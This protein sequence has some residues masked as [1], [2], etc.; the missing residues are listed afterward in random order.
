[1]SSELNLLPAGAKFQAERVRFKKTIRI[2]LMVFSGVW[3]FLTLVVFLWQLVVQYSVEGSEKKYQKAF[4]VYKSLAKEAGDNE[5]LK[6][7]TKM[8][9]EVLM[10]RFEYGATIRKIDELFPSQKIRITDFQLKN[11]KL[12][13]V[14]GEITDGPDLDDLESRVLEIENG[15]SEL[16]S[17][18]KLLSLGLKNGVWS[19]EMEVVI[20]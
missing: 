15:G 12:F 19:F 4:A 11:R 1:M 10:S 9:G 13:L 5:E 8:V 2:Y 18:A 14:K 16:F 20:K 3:F 6:Y 7:R 17:G